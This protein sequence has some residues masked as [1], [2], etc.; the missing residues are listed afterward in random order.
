M[1]KPEIMSLIITVPALIRRAMA[2][3]RLRLR[4]QTLAASPNSLSLAS[5]NR[6]V[7]CV[8]RRDRQHRT[9]S[10]FLHHPH[11]VESHRPAA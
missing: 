3:P 8:E 2:S 7:V 11:I 4:V 1:P 9:K 10:F 5:L 6:L